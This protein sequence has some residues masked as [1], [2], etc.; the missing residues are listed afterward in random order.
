MSDE[1]MPPS[2]RKEDVPIEASPSMPSAPVPPSQMLAQAPAQFP[3]HM[4]YSPPAGTPGIVTAGF[5]LSILGLV[6]TVTFVFFMIGIP[7]AII[8]GVISMI[9]LSEAKRKGQ[10]KGMAITGVILS[11][12]TVLIAV[13]GLVLVL[14]FSSVSSETGAY[15]DDYTTGNEITYITPSR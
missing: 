9:A 7:L 5:V 6:L 1:H 12:I 3:S 11:G 8:G 15:E 10:G 14:L 4:P 2:L 13:I